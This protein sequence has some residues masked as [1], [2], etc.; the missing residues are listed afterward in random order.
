MQPASYVASLL[1]TIIIVKIIKSYCGTNTVNDKSYTE[2][3]FNGSVDF[4]VMQGE[5]C[6]CTFDKNENNFCTYI[7]TQNSTYKIGRKNFRK[8]TKFFPHIYIAFIVFGT[9][10]NTQ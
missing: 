4:I 1:R 10:D 8:S 9:Y 3:K 7:G 5:I 2:K 6:G